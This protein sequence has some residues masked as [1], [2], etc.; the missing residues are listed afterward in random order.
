M[1]VTKLVQQLV[2][3]K[4]SQMEDLKCKHQMDDSN[5]TNLEVCLVWPSRIKQL[6]AGRVVFMPPVCSTSFFRLFHQPLALIPNLFLFHRLR[7]RLGISFHLPKVSFAA[8][9]WNLLPCSERKKKRIKTISLVFTDNEFKCI[10]K[11]YDCI[12]KDS[13]LAFNQSV[14]LIIVSCITTAGL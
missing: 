1:Q 3:T 5:F 10:I 9:D 8:S 14:E 13:Q 4:T 7:R 11:Q 6:T 2:P 12:P